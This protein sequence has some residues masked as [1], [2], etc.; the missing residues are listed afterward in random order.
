MNQGESFCFQIETGNE[1][2]CKAESFFLT[3][4][5]LEPVH[6]QPA[7][8][9]VIHSKPIKLRS[10][11]ASPVAVETVEELDNE[12]N[13]LDM[14]PTTL[15]VVKKMNDKEGCYFCKSLFD[16]GGTSVMV[17]KRA[18]PKDCEIYEYD[19]KSFT[20]TQGS[21]LS[22]G[23]VYLTDL[24]LPE[25]TLTWHIKKIK[26]YIFDAPHIW[27]DLI[28]GQ[29]FLLNVGI[30]ILNSSK[31]CAW[32]EQSIP[33]HPINYFSDKAAM[34][35]LLTVEMIRAHMTA[36]KDSSADVREITDAQKHLTPL[37]LEQ[38][39]EVLSKQEK[40][41]DGSLGCY[42]GCKFHIDLK[43]GTDP[44]HCK[45]PNL[46]PVDKLELTKKE[47]ERQCK[48]GVLEKVY[49]SKWGMSMLV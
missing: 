14:V 28:Y 29:S 18:I 9:Q 3:C 15:L 35:H 6:Y 7:P 34:C 11:V 4:D 32:L 17:N 30:N 8:A 13:E 37:Q 19:G 2:F 38:L 20:T 45:Q 44:Y 24:A 26:A 39:F 33:L 22:P 43:P 42:S 48:I 47:L 41:F 40:L 25:F 12:D 10:A 31:T 1:V 23:F 16:S 49:K 21:F 27:Y 36:T 46:I 5:E